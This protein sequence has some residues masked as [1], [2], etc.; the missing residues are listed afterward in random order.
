[1]DWKQIAAGIPEYEHFRTVDEMRTTTAQLHAEFPGITRLRVVGETRQKEPIELLSIHHG[2]DS[3]NAFLFGAPH[4]NEP[5]GCMTI[6]FLSRR[7]CEDENLR[8]QLNYNWH[9][10]PCIDAD[11]MRL[12]EGWFR[13]PFDLRNYHRNFYR[14][15]SN[16]QVEWSFPVQYKTLTFDQPLSETQALIRCIDELKPRFMFSLHNSESGAVYYHLS[17][18]S[19]PLYPLLRDIPSWF[20][21]Q[22][23]MRSAELPYTLELSPGIFK[24]HTVHQM[25]DFFAAQSAEDPALKIQQGASSFEYAQRYGTKSIIVE[26]PYWDDPRVSDLSETPLTRQ[27]AVLEAAHRSLA[28]GEW[29]STQWER[30]SPFLQLDTPF[31]RAT[32][33]SVHSKN[34]WASGRI[35]WINEHPDREQPAITADAFASQI[36]QRSL[37]QRAVAM[38]LRALEAEIAAGNPHPSLLAAHSLAEQEFNKRADELDELTHYRIVPIRDL[39]GVQVC[40]GLA[41][42]NEWRV[43]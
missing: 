41:A 22:L 37:D 2:E 7:L 36:S 40:A 39:V 33:D 34:K 16:E 25:Y 38:W 29:L 21:L 17:D 12:N 27:E 10:I 8:N 23:D 5:I 6:E 9:F 32:A 43:S 28:T 24:H 31:H 20:G 15:R 42:A 30:T 18:E 26:L 11:H 19:P 4:P 14:P 1:M 35:S 13:G 3:P